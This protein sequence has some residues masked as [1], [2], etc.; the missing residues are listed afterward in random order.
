M[1]LQLQGLL[2]K[3]GLIHCVLTFVKDEGGNLG[4]MAMTLQSIINCK[5][6]KILEVYEGI[7]FGHVTSKT[8]KYATNDDK[9]SIGLFLVSVKGP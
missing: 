2:E 9:V 5:L 3:I 7:C 1:T 4:S 8:C 6:I